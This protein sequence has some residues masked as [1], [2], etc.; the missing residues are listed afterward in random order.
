MLAAT[1]NVVLRT[2][3]VTEQCHQM[4]DLLKRLRPS[5]SAE[6]K[7]KI[8]NILDSVCILTLSDAPNAS[9]ND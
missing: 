4:A 3:S 6:E 5:V 2:F 7:T 1:R 8:S 9:S